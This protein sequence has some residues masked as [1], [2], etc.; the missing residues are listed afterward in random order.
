MKRF[1][2]LTLLALPLMIWAAAPT[3]NSA[4]STTASLTVD[5]QWTGSVWQ[6]AESLIVIKTDTANTYYTFSAQAILRPGQKL[7]YGFVDGATT[8]PT[9]IYRVENPL[10]GYAP[11]TFLIGASYLDS[12]LSQTDANDSIGVYVA[13]GGSSIPEKGILLSDIRITAFVANRD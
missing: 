9:T 10:V 8:V 5:S 6:L 2:F 1:V 11:D 12:L 3:N 4:T 13:C 7:Y